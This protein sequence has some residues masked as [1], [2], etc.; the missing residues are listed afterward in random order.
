MELTNFLPIEIIFNLLCVC[1]YLDGDSPRTIRQGMLRR[2]LYYG[3]YEEIKNLGFWIRLCQAAALLDEGHPPRPTLYAPDWLA[4]PQDEQ[5]AVLLTAWHQMPVNPEK[6]RVRKRLL[7]Y[8]HQFVPLN[9]THQRELSGLQA[10]GFCEGDTLTLWGREF[11]NAELSE[12]TRLPVKPWK[13]DDQE[14][15]APYPPDW[16]LLWELEFYLTPIDPGVYPMD[17]P[18]LRLAA[19]RDINTGNSTFFQILEQGLQSPVP[20]NLKAAFEVQPVVKTY[21]GVLL[22]FSSAEECAFLR[23]RSSWRK[24]LNF[25]LSAHHV[26][27][28]RWDVDRVLARMHKN[29]L[30]SDFDIS[31]IER[32]TSSSDHG[33]SLSERNFMLSIMLVIDG[34]NCPITAPPGLLNKL[35]NQMPVNLRSAAARKARQAL[36]ELLPAPAWLPEEELPPIPKN[37]LIKILDEAVKQQQPLDFYYQKAD[38]YQPEHRRVT[39]L[40]IEQRNLRFYLIAYCHSRRGNRTFRI[41]RI[42]YLNEPVE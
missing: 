31:S 37:Q 7:K 14:L 27:L 15:H 41:D 17:R 12:E 33:F 5:F 42:R 36:S 23:Q 4:L 9:F 11:M 20:T 19:Q 10:L 35:T 34:L 22:E 8:L 21:T 39:P 13:I 38:R 24:D 32:Q 29:G 2:G 18:A 3:T 6:Q 26:F 40:S 1:R 28:N 30:V 25:I 16:S